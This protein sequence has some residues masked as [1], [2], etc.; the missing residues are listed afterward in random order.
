MPEVRGQMPEKI[1][2][3]NFE[4]LIVWQKSHKLVLDVYKVTSEFPK[5]ENLTVSNQLRRSAYSI[6][7]NIAEGCAKSNKFFISH[8][9]ISQGSLEELKYFLILSRDLGYIKTTEFDELTKQTHEIGKI[10][11]TLIN[12]LRSKI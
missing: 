3:G 4:K 8:L 11:Y 10:I 9:I 1:Y 12:N 2:K 5:S 6:P 7:S